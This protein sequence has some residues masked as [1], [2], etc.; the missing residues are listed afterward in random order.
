MS[1]GIKSNYDE[2]GGNSVLL[3]EE[4]RSYLGMSQGDRIGEG[5]NYV[6]DGIR[7]EKLS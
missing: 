7:G 6:P 2:R 5:G 3:G 4:K 1:Q